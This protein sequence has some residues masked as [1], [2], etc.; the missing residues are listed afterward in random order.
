M[1]TDLENGLPT[2][3]A[4]RRLQFSGYNEFEMSVKESLLH[5]YI[6]QVRGFGLIN[7]SRIFSSKIR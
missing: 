4:N 1:R 3:E 7:L 5:K 6:E 2:A